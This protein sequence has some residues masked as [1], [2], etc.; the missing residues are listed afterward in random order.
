MNV[1]NEM[2][3]KNRSIPLFQNI[4]TYKKKKKNTTYTDGG[5]LE[6]QETKWKSSKV[7]AMWTTTTTNSTGPK[8]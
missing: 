4:S 6:H 3:I 1:Q 8:V 2:E 7:G 5:M